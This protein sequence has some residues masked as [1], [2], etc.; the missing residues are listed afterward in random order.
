MI[1]PIFCDT[2]P[3]ISAYMEITTTLVLSQLFLLDLFSIYTEKFC[4]FKSILSP[5]IHL[6]LIYNFSFFI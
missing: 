6:I 2:T 4:H 3:S 5:N 1:P